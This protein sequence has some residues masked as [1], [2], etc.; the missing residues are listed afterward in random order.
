MLI[1][2]LV[3]LGRAMKLEEIV[4]TPEQLCAAAKYISLAPELAPDPNLREGLM[5]ILVSKVEDEPAYQRAWARLDKPDDRDGGKTVL[6]I[7]EGSSPQAEVES[8][9]QSDRHL[10]WDK[11]WQSYLA[12]QKGDGHDR[13][14]FEAAVMRALSRGESLSDWEARWENELEQKFINGT[15]PNRLAALIDNALNFRK[16]CAR[17]RRNWNKLMAA[18]PDHGAPKIGEKRSLRPEFI[19]GYR[20]NLRRWGDNE[21]FMRPIVNLREHEL[22]QLREPIREMAQRLRVRLQGLRKRAQGRVDMR[23]TM[24]ASYKTFGEP[25]RIFRHHPRRKPPRWVVL[26]DVS[27]SVKHATRLFMS[28]LYELRQVMDDDVR[29]FAFVSRVREITELL[30]EREYHDML[31]KLYEKSDQIDLRGYSD[32]GVAFREFDAQSGHLLDCQT[33]LLIIGDARNNRREPRLDIVKKWAER[34]RKVIWFNPDLPKKWN[35]GDSIIALYT[36][37]V[38]QIYDVSTPAKLVTAIERII[39]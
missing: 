8:D 24:R 31:R 28:F 14:R 11:P 15:N 25:M 29:G 26:A 33:V 7:V 16:E 12:Y 1:H 37:A 6:A 32:Y 39:V 36:T 5:P 3:E 18:L 20:P 10:P 21:L 17:I 13:E 38:Q 19:A 35:Q 2:L 23:K 34:A 27:G 4:V 22:L 9:A 30:K